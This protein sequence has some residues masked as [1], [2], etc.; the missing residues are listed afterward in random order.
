MFCLIL[1]GMRTVSEKRCREN[2][3]THFMLNNFFPENCAVYQLMCK[4]T[5]E[6]TNYNTAHAVC[7]LGN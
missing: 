3:N 1:G 4:N 5:A 7:M 6:T 2:Q